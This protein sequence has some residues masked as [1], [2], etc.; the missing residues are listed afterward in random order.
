[1]QQKA[2]Q[3]LGLL[4]QYLIHQVIEDVALR[5]AQ[6]LEYRLRIAPPLE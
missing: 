4:P 5:S 1:M 3:N 2:L 6:L